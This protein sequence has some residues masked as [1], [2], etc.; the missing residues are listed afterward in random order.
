MLHLPTSANVQEQCLRCIKQYTVRPIFLTPACSLHNIFQVTTVFGSIAQLLFFF[1]CSACVPFSTPLSVRHRAPTCFS[2]VHSNYVVKR[3]K[4]HTKINNTSNW[5]FKYFEPKQKKAAYPKTTSLAALL[6]AE[7]FS[8][9]NSWYLSVFIQGDLW[10]GIVFYLY[11][12]TFQITFKDA[13][14]PL[15]YT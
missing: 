2:F 3:L 9:W 4:P 10:L 13:S 12:W 5:Y 1:F 8:V 6:S 11:L 7:D 14:S 15:K